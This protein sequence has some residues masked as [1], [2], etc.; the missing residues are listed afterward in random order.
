LRQKLLGDEHPDVATS[1][2]N[3]A[4]LYRS[5]GRYSEAEPLYQQA[6]ALRQKLLGDEHPDVATS[7]N[8]LAG[9][10][11]SQGRYSEAEPLYQ[12][13]LALRQKLLGDEHPAVATSFNNL[14]HFTFSG[15]LQRGG[16]ALSTSPGLEAKIARRRASRCGHQ[17]Q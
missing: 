7:F 4:A 16:T 2:N 8:N 15:A 5:Q 11:E 3:L 10:Y 6:L 1:F 14:A 9:L 12:Q 17:F 13:A